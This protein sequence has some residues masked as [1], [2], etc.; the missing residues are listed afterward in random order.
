MTDCRHVWRI[1]MLEPGKVMLQGVCSR[2]NEERMFPAHMSEVW[3]PLT[4]NARRIRKEK[5]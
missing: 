3:G 4:V 2:C 5:A 1:E